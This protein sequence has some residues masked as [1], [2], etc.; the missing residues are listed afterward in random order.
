[1]EYHFLVESTKIESAS[2]PYKTAVS[3]ANVKTNRMVTT[4][5]FIK[6][7]RVLPVITLFFWKFLK[8]WFD[9][10]TTQMTIF[11]LFVSAGVLLEG[12]FSL[13]VS[14]NKKDKGK[15]EER[16]RSLFFLLFS[17]TYA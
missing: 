7:N 16:V 6:K 3:E 5:G 17:D 4:K 8:S 9:V 11:L 15:T 14:L 12:T 10:P 13:W 2:F 1:M